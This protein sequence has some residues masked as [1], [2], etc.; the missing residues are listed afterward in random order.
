ML[1]PGVY[2]CVW[3]LRRTVDLWICMTAHLGV[4]ALSDSFGG[5]FS[6]LSTSQVPGHTAV[7]LFSSTCTLVVMMYVP[8]RPATTQDLLSRRWQPLKYVGSAVKALATTELCGGQRHGPHGIVSHCCGVMLY[9][10]AKQI[11]CM[12][13]TAW[14]VLSCYGCWI[15]WLTLSIATAELHNHLWMVDT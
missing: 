2:L 1:S 15:F 5:S 10:L 14:L 3:Q 13:C 7:V 9:A 12:P 11:P 8:S 6:F 4:G